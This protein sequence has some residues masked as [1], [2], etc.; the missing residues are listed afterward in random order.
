MVE[1]TLNKERL[2]KLIRLLSSNVDGEVLAAVAAI[3]RAL[4]SSGKSWH[5]LAETIVD[6][7]IIFEVQKQAVETNSIANN[8]IEAAKWLLEKDKDLKIYEREFIFAMKQRFE[9]DENFKPSQKQINWFTMIVQRFT[10]GTSQWKA[11]QTAQQKTSSTPQ[12]G[13]ETPL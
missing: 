1:E 11:Q 5:D 7:I 2:A 9:F 3:E 8:Y 4:K 12:A 13:H 10:P 6:K